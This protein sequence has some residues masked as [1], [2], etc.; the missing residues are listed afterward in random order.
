MHK[1]YFLNILLIIIW[2]CQS[3][4]MAN[5]NIKQNHLK[6]SQSPYLL[7]HASNPVDWYPWSDIAFKKAKEEDKP[8]FLSIGYSTCHWCHVMEHESFEDSTVASLMNKNFINIKVDRE[9]MPEIDHLYMSV[10]QAMTGR[11]GW[12]LTIIMTPEKKPFFAGTYFPKERIGKRPGMLQLIPSLTN[13]WKTKQTEINKSIAKIENYLIEINTNEP[14]K[15]WSENIINK[16][17]SDFANRFDSDYGGFGK[18]PKFP[19]PHN[20]I[21]L[22]RYSKIYNDTNALKMVE[23]TLDNMR[24]GGIFD[25][26]GFGF[27]RYSTD[28]RWFLPHFEKMLYDQA[29]ISMAYLEAYQITKKQKYALIAEEIFTYV[30]RDMTD[31]NG[32]FYSAEDAD[33]E[34]EEGTFYVWTKEELI[35]ILGKDNG[36]K[37][38]KIFGFLNG[39]NFYDEASGQKTGKNIPY[40]PAEINSLSKEIGM[41]SNEFDTFIKESRKK[42]FWERKKRIHPL[43]DDKILTD[44]NGLMIAALAMGGQI[45]NRPEYTNAAKKAVTFM[46]KHLRDKNGKLF[47]R[48]RKGVSGLDSHIDDY[49]FMIWGLL[50]LYENTFEID[51]LKRA[52]ELTE[53]MIED[54]S[55][56]KGG[57]FIGSKYAEKL[58]VRSK[59]SYDGAI[60]SGNSVAVMNLYRLNKITGN[61]SWK[62]LATKTLRIFSEQAEKS[63]SGF[64]HMLTGFMFHSKNPKELVLVSDENNDEVKDMINK[65]QNIYSPNKVILLKTNS[66]S[67]KISKIAPWIENYHMKDKKMTYY[68]CENFS[69]KQPTTN[70]KTILNYLNEET[71]F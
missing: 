30:L 66:N 28:K 20:L 32:G 48:Y 16:A 51:Y 69:C 61:N 57:F 12:P 60:P 46:E 63:P 1:L 24:L 39:G 54:F 17:F 3:N 22:L 68:L 26:I 55:D 42:L 5:K 71:S 53:I 35:N 38:S 34:G 8:I 15:N 52:I 9:E 33:S 27:H 50:N 43:K 44:W 49:S 4:K 2:N 45:L 7:Q 31:K 37:L 25:H 14:G 36:E 10:C 41:S 59:D 29:M 13:A 21:L 67:E 70:I 58:L 64:A 23:I 11:G 62:E 56:E 40:F 6:N 19:S 47:K 18:S 65:I